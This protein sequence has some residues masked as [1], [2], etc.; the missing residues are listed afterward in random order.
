MAKIVTVPVG[1]DGVAWLPEALDRLWDMTEGHP[2]V[3]QHLA[4]KTTERLND[5]RRRVVGPSDVD[6]AAAEVLRGNK[7]VGGLW[8]NEDDGHVTETHRRIAFL[9][10]ENQPAS[11]TGLPASQV[12]QL[13]QRAGIRWAGRY[14][15]EMLKLEVL[16]KERAG[17]EPVYRIR[18]AFLEEYLSEWMKG[19]GQEPRPKETTST[20]EPLALMLDLENVKITLSKLLEEKPMSQSD[21]LRRRL[22]GAELA[23]RLL[24]AAT[25]HGIPRQ[26]WA[27]ADWDRDIFRGD[28]KAFRNADYGT[29]MAG[30]QKSGASDHV[31]KEKIHWVLR[32]V[33]DIQ[34]YIIATGDGDFYETIKTLQE[35]GKQVVLWATKSNLNR[36]YMQRLK[37]PDPIQIEWLEDIIFGDAYTAAEG[38]AGARA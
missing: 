36:V 34:S 3:I 26:R 10:L 29:D 25:R 22:A 31:L 19:T 38:S 27:V 4:E 32:E 18:G 28:Q 15:E 8:W 13:C 21:S 30:T 23:D 2:W 9:I 5:E 14:L 1:P 24:R 16:T 17:N 37:G 35:K 20:N 33:P 6:W 7:V 12:S 11:R